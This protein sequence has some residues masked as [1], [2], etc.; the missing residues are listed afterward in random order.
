MSTPTEASASTA[1]VKAP[2]NLNEASAAI[3]EASAATNEASAP[4]NE[5]SAA[6][7]EASAPAAEASVA[8]TEASASTT[9]ASTDATEASAPT[10]PGTTTPGN[11][12]PGAKPS[13]TSSIWR[14]PTQKI[15]SY[16]RLTGAYTQKD[17][18]L[19]MVFP[20]P[21]WSLEETQNNGAGASDPPHTTKKNTP[22][23][24]PDAEDAPE[25]GVF[26]QRI[27]ALIESLPWPA[28]T[29]DIETDDGVIDPKGP[30]LPASV[31][32][33]SKLM[34]MLSSESVM[35]GSLSRESVWSMLERLKRS[36]PGV[37]GET[38]KKDG[39]EDGEEDGGDRED[40]GVMMYAPLQ[41][42]ANSKAELADSETV[43]EYVDEPSEGDKSAP[44]TPGQDG[45]PPLKSKKSDASKSGK[46]RKVQERVHWVPSPTQ[47]S[48]Q[49]WWW[50]Y[51]LYLPPPVIALLDDT[52]LAAANRGAMIT[53]SLKWL[54]ER[55][56][57]M[58]FPPQIRP[59]IVALKRLTPL[60][61]YVGVFIAWSWTAIKAR[62]KGDGV[63][64]TA[65]WLLPVA[66]VPASLNAAD[67]QRPGG[68]EGAKDK[69]AVESSAQ[70]VSTPAAKSTDATKPPL[71]SAKSGSTRAKSSERGLKAPP[72]DRKQ[73]GSK[74]DTETE[75]T[76][77]S[78]S[79]RW[80]TL[81]LRRGKSKGKTEKPAAEKAKEAAGKEAEKAEAEP[82]K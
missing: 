76:A 21:S 49:A 52:H 40:S 63:V 42:N 23:D 66:L 10:T 61:G 25:P 56:P 17:K 9:A 7:T 14:N 68:V 20:P 78:L 27:G 41:P 22:P 33:D 45:K 8:P 55:I 43:L 29:K 36:V 2:T 60:V 3:N 48:V 54:L 81:V 50:G 11:T 79:R 77:E 70:N 28:Q 64:L 32:A 44:A 59:A 65:T 4:T 31:M 51:R 35:G 18:R 67:F 75:T 6:T 34:K 47:I 57:T 72:V 1:E 71:K 62:D 82:G 30:P 53:T 74:S 69:P 19:P 12:T 16:I 38:P 24:T 39:E 15:A 73:S 37:S 26:A 13:E 5:A 80:S 46:K 58:L